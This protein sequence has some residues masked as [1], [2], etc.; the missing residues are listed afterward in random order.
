MFQSIFGKLDEFCLW[1]LD[2]I[3]TD[4]RMQFTSKYSQEVFYIHRLCLTL[5]EP[6]HQKIIG[7]VEVTWHNFRTIAH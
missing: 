5:V 4:A 7:H 3:Q 2:I 1:D 6:D